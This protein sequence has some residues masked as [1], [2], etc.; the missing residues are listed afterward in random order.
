MNNLKEI[1]MKKRSYFLLFQQQ[2]KLKILIKFYY[3]KNHTKNV[4]LATFHTKILLMQNDCVFG[5]KPLRIRSI[6]AVGLIRIYDGTR[7]LVIFG[8][9]K[10]GDIRNRIRYLL[11]EK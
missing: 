11:G 4:W 1:N 9:E 5:A 7:Y 2:L 3:M 10:F 6:K 8:S